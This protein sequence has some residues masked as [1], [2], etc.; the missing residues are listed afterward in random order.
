[1]LSRLSSQHPRRRNTEHIRELTAAEMTEISAG[2][3]AAAATLYD[4]TIGGVRWTGG[5]TTNGGVWTTVSG[6]T[7]SA[8]NSTDGDYWHTT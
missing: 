4:V 3:A 6:P 8:G 2:A 1:M 5:T 7:S